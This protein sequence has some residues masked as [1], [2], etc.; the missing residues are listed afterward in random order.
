MTNNGTSSEKKLIF[1]YPLLMVIGIFFCLGG[2][3]NLLNGLFFSERYAGNIYLFV[4]ANTMACIGGFGVLILKTWGRKL[5]NLFLALVVAYGVVN[6]VTFVA[7]TLNVK[8]L[9]ELGYPGLISGLA[10][11]LSLF[12]FVPV[13]ASAFLNKQKV[14]DL[15]NRQKKQ[16]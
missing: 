15:F 8:E 14:K 4:V 13:F 5:L 3:L 16:L 2:F 7:N 11:I 9:K 12:V 10:V 6:A 1:Q